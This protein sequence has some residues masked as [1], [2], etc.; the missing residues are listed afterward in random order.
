MRGLELAVDRGR[1]RYER[2]PDERRNWREGDKQT[3]RQIG[4]KESDENVNRK[5]I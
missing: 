1:G 2:K 3:D 4:V 5:K